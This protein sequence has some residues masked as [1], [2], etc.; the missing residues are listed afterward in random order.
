MSRRLARETALQVLFQLDVTGENES[1]EK[2][3]EHWT[4]EFVVSEKY[5]NFTIELVEG[6]LHHKEEID[7]MISKTAHEWAL[8]MR[9]Y[10]MRTLRRE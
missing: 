1:L 5:K 7:K 3:I 6:T 10:I 9:C 8:D 4:E 2:V